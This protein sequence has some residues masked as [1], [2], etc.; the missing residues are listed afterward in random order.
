MLIRVLF[1]WSVRHPASGYV[2]GI[3]DVVST[4]I[5]VFIGEYC[6]LDLNSLDMPADFDKITD[7]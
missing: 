7:D 6:T 5:I 3:N 4:F 2:Q 1:I